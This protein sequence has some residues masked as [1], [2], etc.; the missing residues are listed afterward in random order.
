[1]LSCISGPALDENAEIAVSDSG[2]TQGRPN[3]AGSSSPKQRPLSPR[4]LA[5]LIIPST[6]SPQ[7]QQRFIKQTSK[8]R[9][10]S[11]STPP[12]VPPKSARMKEIYSHGR[13]SPFTPMSS[14][15]SL[16]TAPTSVSNTPLS[17][18]PSTS[19]DATTPT[20]SALEGRSSPKPWTGPVIAPSPMGHSRGQSESTQRSAYIMGHRRG[21]SEA[22]IMDRGRPKMRADGSPIKRTLSKRS[23]SIEQQAFELLPKGHRPTEA[24]SAL[25]ASEIKTIRKQAMGQAS[26]FEVLSSKNVES[27]SRVS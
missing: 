8:T 20:S 14:T 6:S 1:M 10:R 18:I 4:S 21:E 2:K 23:A 24:L 16:S 5:P 9:L 26:R 7:P 12:E 13:N 22:S 25:P 15:T 11:E 3:R 19:S 27:L 17:T